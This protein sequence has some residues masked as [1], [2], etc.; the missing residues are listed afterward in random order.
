[1]NGRRKYIKLGKLFR[2]NKSRKLRASKIAC[3]YGRSM[4]NKTVWHKCLVNVTVSDMSLRTLPSGFIYPMFFGAKAVDIPTIMSRDK[5]YGLFG[6][7][8]NTLSEYCE[9][10]GV[11]VAK[12]EAIIDRIVAQVNIE[13]PK[14]LSKCYAERYLQQF[15]EHKDGPIIVID[16]LSQ[17]ARDVKGS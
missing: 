3:Y 10:F 2:D 8:E 4:I 1:M 11:D 16:S 9:L 5:H 17:G 6:M 13:A 15:A 7:T 14:N 12:Q